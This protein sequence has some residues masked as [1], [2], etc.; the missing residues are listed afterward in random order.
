MIP[1]VTSDAA[2]A[3]MH[4]QEYGVCRLAGAIAPDDLLAL[5]TAVRHVP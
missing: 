2:E 3:S 4:L 1:A 5:R